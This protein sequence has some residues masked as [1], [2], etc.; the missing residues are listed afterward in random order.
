MAGKADTVYLE[1]GTGQKLGRRV[2][3]F[4]I[5]FFLHGI[6]WSIFC[7]CCFWPHHVA[8]KIINPPTRD[9]TGA[10]CSESVKC[11]N[12]YW[13]AREV[14]ILVCLEYAVSSSLWGRINCY[15]CSLELFK[16]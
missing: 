8:C 13:K 6:L 2:R 3:A 7:C 10:L 11:L 12:Y 5:L 15:F 1:T 14:P 4:H 16:L 9:Q